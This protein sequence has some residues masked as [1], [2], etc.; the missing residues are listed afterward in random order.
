M[1][2]PRNAK[3][4]RGQLDAA[5]F[6]GLFIL[7]LIFLTLAFSGKLVFTPGIRIHLPRLDARL[8]GTTDATVVVA[9]DR[10][11]QYYYR[12][13]AIHETSLTEQLK[14]AVARSAQ[15]LTLEIHIDEGTISKPV[16]RLLNLASR[17]GFASVYFAARPPLDAGAVAD[18][19]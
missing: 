7:L 5:P 9:V 1:K 3:I 15:P 6:A 12:S 11:G 4:F 13:Q 14:D 10:L 19:P 16:F 8:P 17:I 18:Q 2:L